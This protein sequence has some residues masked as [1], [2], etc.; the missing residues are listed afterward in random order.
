MISLVPRSSCVAAKFSLMGGDLIA[1]S[2]LWKGSL[3]HTETFLGN[4][5]DYTT[6]FSVLWISFCV[7]LFVYLFP[8]SGKLFMCTSTLYVYFFL[9]NSFCLTLSEYFFRYAY[10]CL[11]LSVYLFLCTSFCVP[12][13]ESLYLCTT[14]YV[15][16]YV[17]LLLFTSFCATLC[18]SF[19]LPHYVSG[20]ASG[21]H[22]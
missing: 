11:P 9:F 22:T 18:T 13:S 19:C 12:H 15:P 7:P 3:L 2:F 1:G 6:D 10:S 21:K 20:C 8:L 17:C 16:Q 14:F 4:Q 5:M